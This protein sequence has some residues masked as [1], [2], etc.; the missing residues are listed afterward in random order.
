M[1][2]AP[3]PQVP[4]NENADAVHLDLLVSDPEVVHELSLRPEGRERDDFARQSLRLGVLAMRQ[5]SGALD[6]QTI[7]RE[8]ERLLDS[9]RGL[10]SER[11]GQLTEGVTSLLSVYFDPKSG[12]LPQRLERLV[13][14]DGELEGLLT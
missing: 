4:A 14:R 7:Q 3:L 6:A 11:T 5:A 8:G 12:S 9:V 10:L 1:N 2:A 13:K